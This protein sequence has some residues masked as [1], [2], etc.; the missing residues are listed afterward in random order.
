[1]G[2]LTIKLGGIFAQVQYILYTLMGSL[3]FQRNRIISQYFSGKFDKN[4]LS[5]SLYI[6]KQ[7]KLYLCPY[8]LSFWNW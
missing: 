5:S 2:F 7:W 3:S 6:T 4:D 1:M 8:F